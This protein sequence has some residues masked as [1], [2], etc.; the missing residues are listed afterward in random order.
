MSTNWDPTPE[1]SPGQQ[2]AASNPGYGQPAQPYGQQPT[3]GQPA[4]P[5][6]GPAQPGYGPAQPGYGPAQPGYG[7]AQPGSGQAQ[8][9]SGQNPTYGQQGAYGAP[10]LSPQPGYSQPGVGY[11][12][13]QPPSGRKKLGAVIAAVAA[14]ILVVA[15][16]IVGINALNGQT[17]EQAGDVD[18]PRDIPDVNLAVGNC[19]ESL[20]YTNGNM[21]HQVPCA[22]PHTAEVVSEQIIDDEDFAGESVYS[23]ESDAFCMST[24]GEAI[25]V[26]FDTTNMRYH[27]LYPTQETWND[28]DRKITCVVVLDSGTLTGSF[29]AGTA[30]LG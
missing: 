4:Q 15:A 1:R 26:T 24:T 22:D 10:A 8:P 18:S 29:S 23:D 21:L 28:G 6:Y 2:P 16:I 9:G 27:S 13:Q 30:E 20:D 11:P 14:G 7:P 12:G 5:G 3:Y 17:A 19:L 25:P